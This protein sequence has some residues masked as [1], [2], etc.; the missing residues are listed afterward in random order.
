MRRRT[1][2]L[3]A[4]LIARRD[5]LRPNI[6]GQQVRLKATYLFGVR[7]LEVHGLS[8]NDVNIHDLR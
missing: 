6:L 7:C 8:G 2:S 1:G 3:R 4:P 5:K